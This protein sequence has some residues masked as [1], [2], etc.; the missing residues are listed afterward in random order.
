MRA[1]SD[2]LEADRNVPLL[3]QEEGFEQERMPLLALQATDREHPHRP[4]GRANADLSEPFAVEAAAGEPQPPPVLLRGESHQLAAA[5]VADADDQRGALDLGSET[6]GTVVEDV[7]P[8]GAEAPGPC[9]RSRAFHSQPRDQLGDVRGRT[10][11]VS[12]DVRQP[13]LLALMPHR[14][15]LEEVEEVPASSVGAAGGA[16]EGERERA[17]IGGRTREERPQMSPAEASPARRQHAIGGALGLPVG[18]RED[19]LRVCAVDREGVDLDA[20]GAQRLDL[21]VHEG[22]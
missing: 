4:A 7:G 15:G 2:D 11:E 18:L 8:M 6:R 5:E 17:E 12:V 9:P 20:P 19:V 1:V 22:V 14:Y 21:P 16:A 3:E 10:R 13:Q